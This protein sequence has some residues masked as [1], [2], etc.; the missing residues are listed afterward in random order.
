MII[1]FRNY[2]QYL[3]KGD[4]YRYK[5]YTKE[6]EDKSKHKEYLKEIENI[7]EDKSLDIDL[8]YNILNRIELDFEI[9]EDLY[10]KKSI[11]IYL[12]SILYLL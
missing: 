4:N 2:S 12:F 8:I 6:L 10:Q 3:Q 11:Y 9:Y 1:D 5:K 7:I